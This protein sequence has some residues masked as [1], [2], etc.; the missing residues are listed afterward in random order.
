[1]TKIKINNNNNNKEDMEL[2]Q[3]VETLEGIGWNISR[4]I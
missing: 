1:M 4:W 3:D 2:E